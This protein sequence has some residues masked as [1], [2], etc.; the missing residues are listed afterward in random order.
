MAVWEPPC[1]ELSLHQ[2]LLL[3]DQ[4]PVMGSP[5]GLLT[6]PFQLFMAWLGV[7]HSSPARARGLLTVAECTTW[8]EQL[9]TNPASEAEE[10][11]NCPQSWACVPAAA[12]QAL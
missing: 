9:F 6:P 5:W 12:T 10:V 2:D 3:V 11:M 7:P 4:G 1:Q 8:D